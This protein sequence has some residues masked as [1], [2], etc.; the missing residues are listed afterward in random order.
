VKRWLDNMKRL[1]SWNKVNEVFYGFRDSVKD[2]A[3]ATL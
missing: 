2:Q 3:F 1:R